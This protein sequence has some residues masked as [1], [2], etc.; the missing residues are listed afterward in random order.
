MS[1][2]LMP[3]RDELYHPVAHIMLRDQWEAN[4]A[5]DIE[6]ILRLKQE[7]NA[8][9]L[10]HNYQTPEIFHCVADIRATVWLWRVRHKRWMPL[11][12]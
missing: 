9:I 5:A 7:K 3:S 2:S 6:A 12:W 10:A 8:V 1:A 11:P 4:Y